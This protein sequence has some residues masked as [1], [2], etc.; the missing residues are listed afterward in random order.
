MGGEHGF[1]MI[2]RRSGDKLA[3]LLRQRVHDGGG[4]VAPRRRARHD[5]GARLHIVRRDPRHHV[6][7]VDDGAQAHA[8]DRA[9]VIVEGR[10][11]H[12]RH[13]QR[14]AR[15]RL[16]PHGQ[17]L[18]RPAHQE[19]REHDLRARRADVDPDADERHF[20]EFAR[21]LG[22]EIVVGVVLV[23]RLLARRMG[24][25]RERAEGMVGEGMG[26]LVRLVRGHAV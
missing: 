18:A 3:A 11:R 24:V 19:A 2:A 25:R 8:V 7:A 16:P 23:V 13:E 26:G 5:D 6:G 14:F 22:D 17:R 20:L 12:G 21:A 15:L 4:V 9:P 10:H 1:Q